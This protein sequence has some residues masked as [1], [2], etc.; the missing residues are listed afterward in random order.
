MGWWRPHVFAGCTVSIA[1]VT[2]LGA[3]GSYPLLLMGCE[4][5][6]ELELFLFGSPGVKYRGQW[7]HF[8]RCQAIALLAYLF[9]NGGLHRRITLATLLWPEWDRKRGLQAL[10]RVLFSVKK[11][12]GDKWLVA[13]NQTVGLEPDADWWLDIAA[14]E[15]LLAESSKA[16]SWDQSVELLT[17]AA[18]LYRGD[19]LAGFSLKD[20]LE[21]DYWQREQTQ[22]LHHLAHTALGK[23]IHGY[24]AVG[25]WEQAI[26]YGQQRLALDPCDE[27]AAQ[28][29]MRLYAQNDYRTAALRLYERTV[30][31][32]KDNLDISPAPATVRLYEQIRDN[33]P[34]E[35]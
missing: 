34:F 35:T 14:F 7:V 6:A 33:E 12:I 24:E 27:T 22:R 29:L 18:A 20:S 30:E 15:G 17:E 16:E 2:V 32:L 19:F 26:L 23:L 28:T 1:N 5:P 4:M 25:N 10:S 8:S 31:I 13:N 9:I 11:R 3:T 21:F